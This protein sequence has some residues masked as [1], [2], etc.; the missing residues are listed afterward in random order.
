MRMHTSIGFSLL[1][2]FLMVAAGCQGAPKTQEDRQELINK[3]QAALASLSEQDPGLSKV[4]GDS[5]GY[6]I[7]PSVGKG[8][9]VVGGA[10]GRGTVYQGGAQIGFAE[11]T[12]ASI[13]LQLGGQ[14][15]IELLVFQDAKALEKFQ[16]SEFGLGAD[17]SAVA[18][19]AGASSSANFKDGIAV[20]SMPKAGAMFEVS[21]NGQKF[22]YQSNAQAAEEGK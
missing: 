8:G 10:Y 13:G 19:K 17:A 18:V 11:L 4:I 1:A 20:F 14:T 3:S 7:F 16:S 12:Q 2:V 6:A 15:Y 22:K 5:A 21:V 9:L